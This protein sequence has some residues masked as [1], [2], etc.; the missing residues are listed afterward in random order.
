MHLTSKVQLG[1]DSGVSIT[2]F[3]IFVCSWSVGAHFSSIQRHLKNLLKLSVGR[4]L[5]AVREF[6]DQYLEGRTCTRLKYAVMGMLQ[7]YTL[8]TPRD[9]VTQIA[10]EPLVSL[11]FPTTTA[12]YNHKVLMSPNVQCQ[13]PRARGKGNG[14]P[15]TCS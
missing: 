15:L 6:G 13:Q 10:F 9:K 5:S 11:N 2:S 14:R 1:S 8:N 12:T 7:F 4:V 3:L